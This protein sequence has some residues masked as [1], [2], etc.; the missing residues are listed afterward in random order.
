V[1]V[2]V[3]ECA[4]RMPKLGIRKVLLASLEEFSQVNIFLLHDAEMK[5]RA[6]E[7]CDRK[8]TARRKND[9]GRGNDWIPCDDSFGGDDPIRRLLKS[10]KEQY[11]GAAVDWLS[12]NVLPDPGRT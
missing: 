11:I 9:R 5:R 4:K 10:F 8:V 12:I 6:R 3:E 1:C 2:C 7:A